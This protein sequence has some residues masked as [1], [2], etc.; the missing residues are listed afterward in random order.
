[1]KKKYK[2]SSLALFDQPRKEHQTLAEHPATAA[3]CPHE[4]KEPQ[5]WVFVLINTKLANTIT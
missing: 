5:A 4:V 3:F 2:H 1:M